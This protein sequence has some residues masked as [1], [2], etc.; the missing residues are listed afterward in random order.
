V[1]FDLGS[2]RFQI[3]FMRPISLI[4]EAL[5]CKVGNRDTHTYNLIY[6]LKHEN[7]DVA[8]GSNGDTD[9]ST[10][11]IINYAFLSLRVSLCTE[12]TGTPKNIPATIQT[13]LKE[14][15]NLDVLKE[16][17]DKKRD[18]VYAYKSYIDILSE[19]NELPR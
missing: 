1:I 5:P 18:R 16:I 7:L 2:K 3:L 15:C 19:G 10:S 14:L 17:P 9:D 8:Q 12:G 13:A 11:K 6:P 4:W